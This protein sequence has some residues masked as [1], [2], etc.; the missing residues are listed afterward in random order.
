MPKGANTRRRALSLGTVRGIDMF[1]DYAGA[2]IAA[3]LLCAH[4]MPSRIAIDGAEPVISA[5]PSATSCP[6]A[7]TV[8]D[9][10]TSTEIAEPSMASGERASSSHR[11]M[12]LPRTVEGEAN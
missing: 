1:R 11:W 10:V 3:A 8:T 2:L 6:K 4:S 7:A 9:W 5:P 12:S